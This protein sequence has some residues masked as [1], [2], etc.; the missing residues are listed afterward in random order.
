MRFL[1]AYDIVGQAVNA[2]VICRAFRSGSDSRFGCICDTIEGLPI[3]EKYHAG[4]CRAEG[5]GE[6]VKR[7]VFLIV[8]DSFGI[9]Y[10]PDADDFGDWGANTLKTIMQSEQF[11]VPAMEKL[12]L[13]AIDGTPEG[14]VPDPLLGSFGRLQEQSRGKDTTVGHWEIAGVISDRPLPVYPNGFPEE[15]IREFEKQTGRKVLCNRPYSGTEV[16][17]RYGE[18]QMKTGAL[19]VYTSA[20]SVFQIAAHEDVVPP[21]QL[22]EYCRIAREILQ[23]EHGVGR[24]IA[25]PFTGVPGNFVRTSG[26]HDFS[27]APP[28]DTMLDLLRRQ[29]YRT[30]SVGKISDIFAGRGIDESHPTKSN[31]DG[32]QTT[33]E[34]AGA[35]FEGLCF[36]NLVDFDMLYGHRNNIDGYAAAATEFDRWLPGFMDRM[37]DG[38]ILMVTADHGCDPGFPGTDHTREYIPLMICGKDIRQGVNLGTRKTFSDIAATILN[39][40]GIHD[41][42]SGESFLE[43]IL[44]SSCR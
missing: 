35:E 5:D 2:M 41:G 24:V 25:R 26:R 29:G 18:E 34:L 30:I 42:V 32:M 8:L 12:G 43:K 13:F 1:D 33:M 19:I 20:D 9:G 6:K 27:L 17:A 38:D 3:A 21:E 28:R 37:R 39:L 11:R 44:R 7:R 36:T 22:Y 15:V 4:E 14:N 40:F 31:A 23:G 10:E 16:I